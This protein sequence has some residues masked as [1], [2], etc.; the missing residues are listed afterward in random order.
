MSLPDGNHACGNAESIDEM[1]TDALCKIDN[2]WHPCAGICEYCEFT[3]E[4]VEKYEKEE[5]KRMKEAH[6]G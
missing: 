2:E 3:E 4:V 1:S 6:N 5:M